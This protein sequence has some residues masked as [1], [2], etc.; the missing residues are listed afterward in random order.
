LLGALVCD[1]VGGVE[2][3]QKQK[4]K[5]RFFLGILASPAVSGFLLG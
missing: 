1:V 4:K 2:A 3:E 5:L